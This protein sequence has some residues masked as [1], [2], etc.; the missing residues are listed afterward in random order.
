MNTPIADFLKNYAD[1]DTSRFHMPG[2]KGKTFLGV[3]KY[4]ITEISGADFLYKANGI[5][6]ES[7][8][9]ATELFGSGKTCYSTEGSSQ[10]IRAMLHLAI[11]QRCKNALP[12]VVATRNAHKAF[13]YSAGLIGFDIKWIY[14]EKTNSLCRCEI[15]AEQLE[16]TLRSLPALPSAVYITGV[17]YL[18]GT[19]DIES[20]SKVCHKYGAPLLVD[21]AHGAYLH[22]LKE[23]VHPLDLGAD[24]CCDSAHKT[25]PA[26]TGCAYLHIGKNA[27]DSFFENAKSSME[28]FGSTSPSYLLMASLDL[29]NE[30]IFNGYREKLLQCIEKIENVKCQ[31]SK[32]GWQVEK[33]DPLRITIKIPQ[34]LACTK[35]VERLRK[36]KIE[37]E[38]ADSLFAVF[39]ATPENTQ[40]DFD[41]LVSSLGINAEKYSPDEN[42]IFEKTEKVISVR[43]ALLLPK[44]SVSIENALGRICASPTVSCPPAIPIAVSGERIGENAVRLFKY[45]GIDE[46]EVIK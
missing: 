15:K 19:V 31:L 43:D 20:L 3:E 37:C 12:L 44:E 13:I 18:G 42:I 1:S 35:I 7:E 33:S 21:N 11:T 10:C 34:A 8:S 29:C 30:Y 16:N 40:A 45:Y 36:S 6:A 23:P 25:L 46:I 5:I 24:I 22:F 9:I 38:Y 14:P 2:H 27:T 39:M 28:L 4:D 17:D 26:L 41:R 32:N